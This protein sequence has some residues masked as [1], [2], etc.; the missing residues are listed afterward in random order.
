[1]FFSLAPKQGSIQTDNGKVTL[2]LSL[3]SAYFPPPQCFNTVKAFSFATILPE[4]IVAPLA[5]ALQ[6][7]DLPAFFH[8]LECT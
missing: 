6:T 4:G 5:E 8:S 1:M 2:S 3:H 7:A